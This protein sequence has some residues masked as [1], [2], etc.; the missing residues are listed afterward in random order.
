MTSPSLR[1]EKT[2]ETRSTGLWPI[3]EFSVIVIDSEDYVTNMIN[4]VAVEQMM[5]RKLEAG[6]LNSVGDGELGDAKAIGP[7]RL[8]GHVAAAHRACLNSALG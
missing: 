4:V 3:R 7:E 8:S 6:L 1:K 2:T 5:I